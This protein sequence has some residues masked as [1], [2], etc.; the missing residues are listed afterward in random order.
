MKIYHKFL[1]FKRFG[2]DFARKFSEIFRRRKK[3]KKSSKSL[4]F[5]PDFATIKE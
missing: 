3:L 2:P 1:G 5:G 4:G